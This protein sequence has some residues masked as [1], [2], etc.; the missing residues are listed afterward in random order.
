M[1]SFS[2]PAA[3]FAQIL[4]AAF[5]EIEV[6][7]LVEAMENRLPRIKALGAGGAPREVGEAGFDIVRTLLEPFA[8]ALG[9]R[10]SGA[11]SDV[12]DRAYRRQRRRAV[13]IRPP[14]IR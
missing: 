2:G 11:V 10:G 5:G 4:E 9:E 8:A 7:E 6:F 12:S 3:P 1:R 13:C 14:V